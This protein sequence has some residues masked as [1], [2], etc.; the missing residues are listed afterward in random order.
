MTVGHTTKS[1]A[2][3][4]V[5]FCVPMTSGKKKLT[6]IWQSVRLT[7]TCVCM[8]K[9]FVDLCYNFFLF[10]VIYNDLIFCLL[11][12]P[13]HWH[14][15]INFAVG[16]VIISIMVFHLDSFQ[17]GII[18]CPNGQRSKKKQ[19]SKNICRVE[20]T[21]RNIKLSWRWPKHCCHIT[22]VF[23]GCFQKLKTVHQTT[24]E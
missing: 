5:T 22:V 6:L 13:P 9:R 20:S 15:N 3:S 7:T 8:Y 16:I 2:V 21:I 17:I 11:S 1:L 4:Q 23:P 18:F 19:N 24:S 10:L 14:T 12:A